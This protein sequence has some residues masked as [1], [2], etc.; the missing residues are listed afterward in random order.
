MRL[1]CEPCLVGAVAFSPND[2]QLA[3]EFFRRNETGTAADQ[4]VAV[5]DIATGT[6]VVLDVGL[7]I[8]P[9]RLEPV[10]WR[11]ERTILAVD[12]GRRLL[13]IPVDA[14]SE[15][16]VVAEFPLQLGVDGTWEAWSPDLSRVAYL[17]QVTDQPDG[18]QLLFSD[19]FVLDVASG[20]TRRIVR[21]QGDVAI[22][23]I[24]WAPDNRT[25]TYTLGTGLSGPQPRTILKVADALEGEPVAVALGVSPIAWRPV[26]R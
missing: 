1:D 3:V 18:G 15:F 13:A 16:S 22:S 12:D 17:R 21:E 5:A 26:W 8:E 19:V 6:G 9:T 14:P 20:S 4:L 24:V 11:D 2:T 23:Q 10:G 7:D 25:F